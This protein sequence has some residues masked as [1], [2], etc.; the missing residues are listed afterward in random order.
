[1]GG[2]ASGV[3]GESQGG[4]AM[5]QLAYR[6]GRVYKE[7]VGREKRC[8]RLLVLIA[9]VLALPPEALGCTGLPFNHL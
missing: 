1:V 9:G 7:K 8:V 6:P 2:A 3:G 5:M 4:R